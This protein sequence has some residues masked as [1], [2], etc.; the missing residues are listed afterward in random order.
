MLKVRKEL[1]VGCGLCIRVCSYGAISLK[2]RKAEIDTAKCTKCN[3]CV[4]ICPTGAIK[5]EE[6]VSLRELRKTI[7]K[8]LGEVSK[9]QERLEKLKLK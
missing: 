6:K 8:L 3:Q 1:C 2:Y 9:T 4:Q 5:E 7:D